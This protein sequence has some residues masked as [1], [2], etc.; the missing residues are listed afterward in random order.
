MTHSLAHHFLLPTPQMRDERFFDSLI[1]LCRDNAE[2]T[3]GFVVNK[4]SQST[5]VGGLLTD[6]RLD[7]KD[8]MKIPAMNAGPVR[9]EAGFVL[10]TGLPQFRSS[11][12]LSENLSLT[13]SQDILPHLANPHSLSHYLLCMGFCN[14]SKGQLAQEI[15]AG[16]WL[17]CPASLEILFHD[18]HAQK[19]AL[20]YRTLGINPNK[21]SGRIGLA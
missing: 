8:T 13:T 5:S 12:A 7:A 15:Q 20:A 16:S 3:W 18:D 14:W 10:H 6:L 17:S 1:Y 19:L 11:F 9:P 4:P 2:G 21:L